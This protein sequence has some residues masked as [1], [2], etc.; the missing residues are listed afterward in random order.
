MLKTPLLQNFTGLEQLWYVSPFFST[1]NFMKSKYR[2]NIFNKIL[3]PKSRYKCKIY[4]S[5]D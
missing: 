5:Y 3:V 4:T 2:S 1:V